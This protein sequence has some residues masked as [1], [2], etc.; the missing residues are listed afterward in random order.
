MH[1]NH[2]Q[3]TTCPSPPPSP[4]TENCLPGNVPGVKQVRDCY[5]KASLWCSMNSS[6]YLLIQ[7]P[8]LFS[9]N[10]FSFGDHKLIFSVCVYGNYWQI[11]TG[12]C[13]PS[14]PGQSQ[15]LWAVTKACLWKAP[16]ALKW[17]AMPE[18]PRTKGIAFADLSKSPSSPAP[19]SRRPQTPGS[20]EVL[21]NS[22][23]AQKTSVFTVQ[24]V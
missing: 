24:C 2:P 13:S 19:Q 1:L 21:L 3:T 23:K 11:Q 8:D 9:P 14:H 12:P 22:S 4:S 15:L 10:P 20:S 7:T 16:T 17:A 18:W 6:V 5:S